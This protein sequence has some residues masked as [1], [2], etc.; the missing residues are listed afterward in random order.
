MRALTTEFMTPFEAAVIRADAAA[1]VA[2][3]EV[4]VLVT[5]RQHGTSTFNPSTGTETSTSTD[6]V[7]GA[8]RSVV[9]EREATLAEGRYQAGD[10]K[11]TFDRASL[12]IT[13]GDEDVIIEGD[14]TFKVKVWM[15]DPL[16]VLWNVVATRVT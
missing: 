10:V 9:T 6:Y 7:V 1:L 11:Y 15:T 5:Y 16:S 13:P 3:Q 12:T 2:D 8:V 14:E 4:R